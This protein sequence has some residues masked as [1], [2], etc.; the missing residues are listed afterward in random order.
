MATPTAARFAEKYSVASDQELEMLARRGRD[1]YQ[2][3]AWSALVAE[4]EKRSAELPP[5][6]PP[7]TDGLGGGVLIFLCITSISL[8]LYTAYLGMVLRSVVTGEASGWIELVIGIPVILVG[9]YGV[10]LTLERS[11]RTPRYWTIYCFATAVIGVAN[12]ILLAKTSSF[13]SIAAAFMWML[14]WANSNR[15]SRTFGRRPLAA[16]PRGLRA[17]DEMS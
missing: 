14:Y 7:Q 2:E 3:E 4:L 6:P 1:S 9:A 5:E 16:S 10:R 8:I 15:V 11:P 13:I 12:A 17:E